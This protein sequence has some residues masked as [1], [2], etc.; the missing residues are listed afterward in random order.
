[1]SHHMV[2]AQHQRRASFSNSRLNSWLWLGAVISTSFVMFLLIIAVLTRYYIYPID[3]NTNRKFPC[4]WRSVLN[5]LALSFSIL[6]TATATFLWNKKQN[7][8][9]MRKIRNL[10]MPTPMESPG[11]GTWF[12]NVDREEESLPHQTLAQNVDVHFGQ[13]PNVKSKNFLHVAF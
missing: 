12:C 4:T 2:Q 1:M 3:G 6:K 11:Q 7:N 5:M 9:E 8:Q 10:D 13:R